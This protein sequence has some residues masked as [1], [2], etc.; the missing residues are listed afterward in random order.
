MPG[1]PVT[2]GG[3]RASKTKPAGIAMVC[4]FHGAFVPPSLIPSFCPK[5]LLLLRSEVFSTVMTLVPSA[6]FN[7]CPTGSVPL[8]TPCLSLPPSLMDTASHLLR[9]LS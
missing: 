7:K 4:P 1:G 9:G 3:A 5:R 2:V 8:V 6:V